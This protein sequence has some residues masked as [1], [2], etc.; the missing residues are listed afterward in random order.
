M[1]FDSFLEKVMQHGFEY[2]GLYYGVYRGRVT[3]NADPEDRG[4]V[5][6]T[7]PGAALAQ[8]P[9]IWVPPAGFMAAGLNRGWFWPPEVGD[10]VWVVFSQG[11]T[12]YPL[13]YLPGYFGQ[14]SNQSEVPSELRAASDHVPRK[15]G[16]VT[17]RGHRFIFD[18][19]PDGD[20]IELVWHKPAADTDRTA[21]PDRVGGSTASLRFNPQGGIALTD[22]N[23][24]TVTLDAANQKVVI[25]DQHGNTWTMSAAGVVVDCGPRNFEVNAADIKLNAT[26]VSVGRG[27]SH[28]VAQGDSWIQW[29]LTHTHKTGVGEST[30]PTQTP[31]ASLNSATVTVKT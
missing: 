14:A 22:A 5:K 26:T 30:P 23:N 12:R 2:F 20:A 1:N 29:A 31:T 6:L 11:Q 13:C 10:S 4:R 25:A 24:N 3:D 16:V 7:A 17:R 9:N 15:R 8:P 27:A 18:E 19:T 21:T 28:P